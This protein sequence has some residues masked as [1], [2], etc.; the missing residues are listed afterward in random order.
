[1][2]HPS[3]KRKWREVSQHSVGQ[4]GGRTVRALNR[5]KR[6]EPGYQCKLP[7]QKIT[8]WTIQLDSKLILYEVL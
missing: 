1:M 8:F 7:V 4:V 2:K 6:R 5:Q 3:V